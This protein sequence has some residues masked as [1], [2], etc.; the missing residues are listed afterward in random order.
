MYVA[1]EPPF[2]LKGS[3]SRKTRD[4]DQEVAV[5]S[6]PLFG[7]GLEPL[8]IVFHREQ[9]VHLQPAANAADNRRRFIVREVEAI[10]LAAVGRSSQGPFD[11]DECR[12]VRQKS[13]LA[14][15][16][17]RTADSSGGAEHNG[18]TL[19]TTPVACRRTSLSDR[20]AMTSSCVLIAR[21][22]RGHRRFGAGKDDRH[23][24]LPQS[25]RDQKRVIGKERRDQVFV[26]QMQLSRSTTN[27]LRRS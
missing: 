22:A 11:R 14:N 12:S 26:E 10:F 24:V 1:A 2:H 7:V 5:E 17:H 27:L 4:A 13:R 16:P 21:T 15:T 9:L 8:D 25:C 18:H 3:A 23:G 6:I 19:S 20:R